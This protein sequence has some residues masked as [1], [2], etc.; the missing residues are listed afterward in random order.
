MQTE[1]TAEQKELWFLGDDKHWTQY[2]LAEMKKYVFQLKGQID[3]LN[4]ELK[5]LRIINNNR[6]K[7]NDVIEVN[8][9]LVSQV[10]AYELQKKNGVLTKDQFAK[11]N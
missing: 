10:L 6:P 1:T 8:K 11:D 9:T 5:L 3:D 7:N 2:D 4:E